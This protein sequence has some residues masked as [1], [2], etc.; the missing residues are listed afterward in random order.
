MKI[1]FSNLPT[2][3]FS[4]PLMSI[5]LI[6]IL[7]LFSDNYFVGAVDPVFQNCSVPRYCGNQLIS[8]PFYTEEEHKQCGFPGFQ[9]SCKNKANNGHS[10]TILEVKF[11]GDNHIVRNIFYE[12]Q[13]LTVSNA[14]FSR[15]SS[16]SCFPTLRNLSLPSEF[17]LASN[18]NSKV[19][20]LQNCSSS[21]DLLEYSI[22]CSAENNNNSVLAFSEEDKNEVAKA[23]EECGNGSSPVVDLPVM[24]YNSQNEEMEEVLSRGF[25]L[26]WIASD[27]S[28]CN[29]THGKCG[30]NYT[31]RHFKCYCSD[32]PHS[33]KCD[34]PGQFSSL[35]QLLLF[36]FS[37]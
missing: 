33:A 16:T 2:S 8:F 28:V 14:A 32:R 9:L 13:S 35:A 6:N 26:N 10:S 5:L 30:F 22:G 23:S 36:N 18:Q 19:F 15:Q 12:N 1:L 3:A 20:L 4:P 7:L 27:C 37:S 25:L 29:K 11:D 34:L 17:T 24:K 31:T 21:S